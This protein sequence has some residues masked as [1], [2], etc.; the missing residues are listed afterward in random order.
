MQLKGRLD[1]QRATQQAALSTNQVGIEAH[2]LPVL[3]AA[4]CSI[5][6]LPGIEAEH[7]VADQK[8]QLTYSLQVLQLYIA[9]AEV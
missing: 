2:V 5:E 3:Q 8:T 7:F 1:I 6:Y 4:H 9:I